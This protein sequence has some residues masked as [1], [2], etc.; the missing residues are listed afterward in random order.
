MARLEA[1]IPPRREVKNH[2][3][4]STRWDGFVFRPGDVVIATWAK[5]GTTWLQQIVGQ[6]VF[7]G[8]AGVPVLDV[9]PWIDRRGIPKEALF[10]LLEKQTHRRFVKT[11]L[12]ADALPIVPEARYIYIGRDGRD[13]VWSWYNHHRNLSP[14]VFE[15]MNSL[16]DRVGPPFEP[17]T[18][19][20]RQCFHRWL[21]EDGYPLWPFWSLVRSW[22]DMREQPNVLLMHFNDLK[23][24]LEGQIRRIARFLDIEID[25][26]VWPDI[27]RHSTF[28]Y[29]KRN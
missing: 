6:L 14:K 10:A 20:V 8:A 2:S 15:Y 21:D 17:L 9:S 29:M 27:V 24:D 25:D 5:G 3:I 1:H 4:D 7:R 26:A 23:T 16:P 19:D 12:P 22:W 13:V 11:H 28:E 18:C